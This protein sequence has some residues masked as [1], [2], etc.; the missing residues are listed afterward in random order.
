MEMVE[1]DDGSP[2]ATRRQA[3]GL[4]GGVGLGGGLAASSR[5]ATAASTSGQ[6]EDTDN[7]DLLELPNH[8]G[9]DGVNNVH[10]VEP[11]GSIQAAI[12]E[13]A[14]A[15]DGHAVVRLFPGTGYNEGSEIHL[16]P[17]VTLDFNGGFLKL[18]SD[19][20]GIFVDNGAQIHDATIKITTNG[21]YTSSAVVLDTSRAEHGTYGVTRYRSGVHVEAT[22]EGERKSGRGLELN[23]A[24]SNGIQIGNRFDLSIVACDTAVYAHTGDNNG[25]I[26]GIEAYFAIV[27]PRIGLDIKGTGE[28]NCELNGAMQPLNETE[29]GIRNATGRLGPTWYGQLWDSWRFTKNALVGEQITVIGSTCRSL[30]GNTDGSHQ[31]MGMSFRGSRINMYDY[32]SDT[33][34]IL[35]NNKKSN[36]FRIG[37]VDGSGNTERYLR[38]KQN[39]KITPAKDG[40]LQI[41]PEDLRYRKPRGAGEIAVANNSATDSSG[42]ELAIA[43][44]GGNWNLWYGDKIYPE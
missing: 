15:N 40:W 11:G 43:G 27:N 17:Q 34:W 26:N 38:I 6:W 19:H 10:I 29:I 28:F 36:D 18:G 12:D 14:G 3:L 2:D 16:R 20:N 21:S 39:G 13:A 35:D 24:A 37:A 7:D 22:I 1:S 41:Y 4:L 31:Q 42:P 5:P 9:I 44:N 25:Y 23:D 8:A 30:K 32:E 33:R